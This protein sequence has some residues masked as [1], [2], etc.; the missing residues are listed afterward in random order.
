MR[1]LNLIR[2]N[3]D[4]QD[5]TRRAAL[6]RCLGSRVRPVLVLAGGGAPCPIE[7]RAAIPASLRTRTVSA[8][9]PRTRSG[10]HRS[11]RSSSLSASRAIRRSSLPR[12]L[13]PTPSSLHPELLPVHA[14]LH[15]PLGTVSGERA[16]TRCPPR[17]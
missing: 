16:A 6:W 4:E 2:E 7:S 11:R 12:S 15:A 9:T 10:A 5:G 8:E 3:R 1:D 13:R 14:A 17:W